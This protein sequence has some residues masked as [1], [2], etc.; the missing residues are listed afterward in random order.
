MI[1]K[2]VFDAIEHALSH[3]I[4]R[5]Q[6]Q[7]PAEQ[8]FNEHPE[9]FEMTN[10]Y[11]YHVSPMIENPSD[12]LPL[13]DVA[14]ASAITRY[15]QVLAHEPKAIIKAKHAYIDVL[16]SR[17]SMLP[18]FVIKQ[19]KKAWDP[20]GYTGITD[21]LYKHPFSSIT[22]G[23]DTAPFDLNQYRVHILKVISTEGALAR[24]GIP[25]EIAASIPE[26]P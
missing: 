15:Y 17:A 14:I 10:A 11:A 26:T 4:A 22:Y 2:D 12:G 19:Y 6:L 21:F 3:C 25:L 16:L 24:L 7:G 8:I 13:I 5:I 20:F 18:D 9:L 23:L 1:H